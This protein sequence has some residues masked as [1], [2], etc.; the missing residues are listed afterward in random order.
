MTSS[1]AD[2]ER[3]IRAFLDR[4]D[5]SV[6]TL[7]ADLPLY[8]DGVGLDSLETAELSAILEDEFGRDPF[9]SDTMPQTIGDITSFYDTAV[10]DA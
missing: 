7:T 1:Q 2:V 10:A 5:K 9:N 3:T 6:E 4:A 8:A